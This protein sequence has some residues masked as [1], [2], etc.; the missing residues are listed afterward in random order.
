VIAK[1]IEEEKKTATTIA[2]KIYKNEK[3][4]EYDPQTKID[5]QT[6]MNLME[7]LES[8]RSTRYKEYNDLLKQIKNFDYDKKITGLNKVD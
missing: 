3:G 7:T 4:V 1:K 5:A 2:G 8:Y 6:K